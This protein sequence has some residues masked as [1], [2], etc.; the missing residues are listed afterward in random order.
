[1]TSPR[2]QG[3]REEWANSASHAL[4][5]L[6]ATAALPLLWQVSRARG[7]PA[8]HTAAVCVF[9]LSMMA[10]YAA[11]AV[12]HTLPQ[13]AAK[14]WFDRADR[15]AIYLFIAGSYGPFAAASLHAGD[16][17]VWLLLAAVWAAALAGTW[18]SMRVHDVSPLW[19]TARY[20]GMGWLVLLA[21]LPWIGQL[22]QA[23]IG[24]LLAGGAAYSAGAVLFL[25][26]ARLPFAHLAWHLMV[27]LGS[28]LHGVAVWH[29]P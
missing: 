18:L 4:G 26:S 15:A 10:L 12:C 24:W 21:A 29:T 9:A 3:P 19:S 25:L 23:G 20:L 16:G 27:M 22:Q 8:L 11:S 14:A 2:H 1:M 17:T 5:F 6:L 13:G 7:A 28:G